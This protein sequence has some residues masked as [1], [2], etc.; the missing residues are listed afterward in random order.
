[1]NETERQLID[2]LLD[3]TLPESEGAS[4]LERV[5]NDPVAVAYLADRTLLHNELRQSLKRRKL[6]Q[7]ATAS[8]PSQATPTVTRPI[9]WFPW[10]PLTAAAAGLI[11]GLFSASVVFGVGA[12]PRWKGRALFQEGF[13]DGPAPSVTGVPS[14]PGVWS[15]DF[16]QIVP[17]YQGVK[18][19]KGKKMLRLLRSDY[20]GRTLPQPS[21]Q[22]DVMRVIDVRP[23]MR[24]AH[25]SEAVVTLSALFN[26]APFPAGE[27]DE[28]M[29]TIYAL[30]KNTELRGATENSVETDALAFAIDRF[31]SLDRD[32]AT[33]QP[34]FT[35]LLL[36]QSTEFVMLK[37]SVKRKP[38]ENESR[39]SLPHAVTFA[40]HFIDDVLVSIRFRDDGPHRVFTSVR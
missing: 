32:P 40:G 24:E 37:V 21:R 12:N 6:S 30:G 1:M 11:I 7:W 28:G 5:E 9:R 4:L 34:A 16:S 20:E 13:E 38:S 2:M 25:G 29:V 14:E 33:W 17:E 10:R 39:S 26:A 35:R 31:Q 36:P 18:P 3:G 8:T 19:A 15:G 27:R 23:L 22:G